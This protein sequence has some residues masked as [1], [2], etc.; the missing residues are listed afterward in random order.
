MCRSNNASQFIGIVATNDWSATTSLHLDHV[1]TYLAVALLLTSFQSPPTAGTLV[2]CT[3][4]RITMH[5][6]S[7]C[8]AR[9]MPLKCRTTVPHP[10][11]VPFSF[12]IRAS[13]TIWQL[14]SICGN[15]GRCETCA[16]L[17]VPLCRSFR[18]CVYDTI[19]LLGIT[20]CR[21]LC[22]G[23]RYVI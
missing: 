12:L 18:V 8:S 16:P 3:S 5:G 1:T 10:K 22:V 20:V 21:M 23:K 2:A 6:H 7:L 11:G 13:V 15:Y 17:A 4:P 9:H 19:L 14:G